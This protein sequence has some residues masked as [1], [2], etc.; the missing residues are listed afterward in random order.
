MHF[1]PGEGP[2]RGLL[3]DCENFAEGSFAALKVTSISPCDLSLLP[4]ALRHYPGQAAPSLGGRGSLTAGQGGL[5][6]GAG[7]ATSG[8]WVIR[9]YHQTLQ[10][11]S[12]GVMSNVVLLN[13]ERGGKRIKYIRGFFIPLYQSQNFAKTV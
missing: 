13:S 9:Y 4:P 2:S 8:T 3:R 7:S 10:K 5:G 1:Q 11:P 12:R 6:A